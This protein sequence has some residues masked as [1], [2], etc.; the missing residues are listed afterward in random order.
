MSMM[1]LA[2]SPVIEVEPLWSM[3]KASAPGALRRRMASAS[4]AAANQDRR[5]LFQA[6]SHHSAISPS[7]GV[8]QRQSSGGAGDGTQPAPDEPVEKGAIPRSPATKLFGCALEGLRI[9]RLTVQENG[10]SFQLLNTPL[11]PASLR[12][13]PR[14]TMSNTCSRLVRATITTSNYPHVILAYDDSSRITLH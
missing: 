9:I 14:L 8:A 13:Y 7:S 4:N 11:Q 5:R 1:G 3:R 12:V 6:R 2:L 10:T